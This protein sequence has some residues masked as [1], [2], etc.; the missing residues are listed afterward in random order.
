LGD[1]E[2]VDPL[3]QQL[4]RR[5]DDERGAR[6][7]IRALGILGDRRGQS[8]LVAAYEDGFSPALVAEA[9][10]AM[11]PSVVEP[12]LAAL[13]AHPELAARRA[14]LAVFEQL[15][16]DDLARLLEGRATALA[17]ADVASTGA[18]LLK[19]ASAHTRARRRVARVLVDKLDGARTPLRRAVERAL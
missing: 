13:E 6:N 19:L 1:A 10:R 11:G 5:D 7:A 9:L 12:L 2:I 4:A 18:L 3:V 8:E 17:A 15:D 14:R 16:E